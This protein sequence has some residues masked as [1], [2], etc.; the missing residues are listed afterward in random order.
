MQR[1]KMLGSEL[2]PAAAGL[3]ALDSG[4]ELGVA[5]NSR[6]EQLALGTEQQTGT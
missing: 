2:G 5:G 1:L 3:K 4:R 6:P